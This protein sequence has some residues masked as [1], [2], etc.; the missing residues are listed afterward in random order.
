MKT[1]QT[2]QRFFV[3]W[4]S[5]VL[6]VVTLYFGRVILVPFILAVLLTFVLTPLVNRVQH[7]GLGRVTSVLVV[8]TIALLVV[9]GLG[10]VLIMQVTALAAEL[11]E[12]KE[13]IATKAKDLS[14]W[15]ESIYVGVFKEVG[16]ISDKL[17]EPVAK[18]AA[19]EVVT[20]KTRYNWELIQNALATTF[21]FLVDL[22]FV[23]LLVIFMLIS[24][25]DLRNRL[26]RLSGDKN[27]TIMT[28]ALDDA[29][30]R[31]SA[32]LL[33]Q[34]GINV[35]YGIILTA[36]LWVIGVPYALLWG[37][38]AGLMR[39]VP[40]IGAL[41]AIAF[42]LALS[43]A[44]FQAWWP[45]TL[46]FILFV[47]L[48][49]I[50]ANAIEPLLFGHSIGVSNTAIILMAVFWTWVWGA[51]G[52]VLATPLTA[53]LVVLG[54]YLPHFRFLEILLGDRPVM[55][56]HLAFFQRLIARDEDEAAD[57]VEKYLEKHPVEKIYDEL[58]LPA[59]ALMRAGYQRDE[60][61]LGDLRF[62]RRAIRHMLDEYGGNFAPAL[63]GKSDDL[64]Q[65]GQPGKVRGKDAPPVFVLGFPIKNED[66]QLALHMFGQLVSLSGC[67]YEVRS[68]KLLTGELRSFIEKEG[69]AILVLCNLP[70]G[71]LMQTRLTC[72]RLRADFPDLPIMAILWR[73]DKENEAGKLR[74]EQAGA[75]YAATSLL[76]VRDKVV[77][78][79]PV[80]SSQAKLKQEAVA[81]T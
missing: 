42:P 73:H 61:S 9:A 10:A 79:L 14:D 16:D 46:V 39:Y 2:W 47:V 17:G 77:E 44:V 20:V 28:K 35:G 29:S 71:G 59:L 25:E 65:R 57:L 6:L 31:I 78:L 54:R 1:I 80:L 75:N 55:P 11:P 34:L 43:M 76:E 38:I 81:A 74:I 22:G 70:P 64:S 62:A 66:D 24:R 67:R 63:E 8:V 49:L 32:F 45:L 68:H 21:T 48:E 5:V 41:I 12:H 37:F 30:G 4:G 72:K 23:I 7:A 58:L 27:L 50:T 33:I 60:L 3:I 52:L 69:T 19:R 53:C 51:L 40:Y 18:E 15:V 26:I 56:L 36:G 13:V